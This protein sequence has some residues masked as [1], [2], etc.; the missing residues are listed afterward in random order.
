MTLRKKVFIGLLGLSLFAAFSISGSLFENV[1]AR[2]ICVI[3][4]PVSGELTIHFDQ[5]LKYQGFGKVTLYDK[6]K[7]YSLVRT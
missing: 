3:Q 7:E 1:D 2:K 6:E 4:A 5:G